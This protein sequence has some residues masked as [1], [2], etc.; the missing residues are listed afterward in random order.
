MMDNVYKDKFYFYFFLSTI[1]IIF[2]FFFLSRMIKDAT[3]LSRADCGMTNFN[4][5]L[6]LKI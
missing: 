1:K 6:D 4:V 5:I 3:L 2:I